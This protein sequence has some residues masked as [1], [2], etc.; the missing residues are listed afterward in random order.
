MESKLE[1]SLK[2]LGFKKKWLDDKSGYWLEKRYKIKD[3]GLNCKLIVEPDRNFM[4]NTAKVGRCF[5]NYIISNIQYDDF[6]VG[7][8]D[9][10]YITK[11]LKKYGK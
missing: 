2:K 3:L 5:N 9:L 10:K 7:K 4:V 11:G 1:I 6:K 8:I